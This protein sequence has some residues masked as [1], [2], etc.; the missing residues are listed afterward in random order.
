MRRLALIGSICAVAILGLY[1]ASLHGGF[2]C[3]VDGQGLPLGRDFI[4]TWFYGRSFYDGDPGRFYD[5]VIYER[6]VGA[7]VPLNATTHIWSY[8]PPFLLVAAP[9][10]PLAYPVALAT[11]TA[12]G[13]A[14]LAAVVRSQGV[15]PAALVAVIVSP[16]VL[17]SV[18]FG[19]VSL[20]SAAII[21]GALAQMDRRPV[22]A[23]LLV[24]LLIVKPQTAILFPVLFLASG[25]WLALFAAVGGCAAIVALSIA[26][27]GL[28]PWTAFVSL[29]LPAQAAE[30]RSSIE[31][32]APIS[33]TPATAATLAGL[34][35]LAVAILQALASML[36]VGIVALV[37]RR[38]T[39][40]CLER[41]AFL[42]CS[43][44]ASPYQLTHDLVALTAV[45][46]I[47]TDRRELK[48]GAPW[49]FG[50]VFLP[51]VQIG[52]ASLHVGLAALVPISLA[53]VLARQ[54]E[55]GAPSPAVSNA[56]GGE[57]QPSS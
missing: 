5:R 51:T 56:D 3:P 27:N 9:F 45:V 6:V 18:L 44:F 54:S 24:S 41:V 37:A 40:P 25:R 23:G 52:L 28:A 14:A 53:L 57:K 36:A 1:A 7:F 55:A 29:G 21:V 8:P 11:W 4:N 10:G 50:I 39:S 46:L 15:S 19:Q 43:A 34:P 49:L 47:A 2:P 48:I 20:F 12:L 22:V 17:S 42:A 38:K 35:P 30:M 33:I 13:L 32:L 26:V 31:A 16:A